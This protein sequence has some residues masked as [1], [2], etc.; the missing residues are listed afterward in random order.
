MKVLVTV[1]IFVVCALLQ[2]IHAEDAPTKKWT[3]STDDGDIE[4][5]IFKEGEDCERTAQDGDILVVQYKGMMPVSGVEF[6][7]T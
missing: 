1:S 3:E 2:P 7:N 6:D 4:I 5:Q